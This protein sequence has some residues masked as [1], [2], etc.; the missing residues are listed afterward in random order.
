M[1]IK[2]ER[3]VPMPQAGIQRTG[4]MSAMKKMSVGDSFLYPAHRVS[5]VTGTVW[6]IRRDRPEVK[7]TTRKL[8]DDEIRVWRTK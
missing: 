7:F 8:N 2:I 6:F 4:L 5:S 1:T 3:N